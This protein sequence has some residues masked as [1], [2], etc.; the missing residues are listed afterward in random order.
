MPSECRP[1]CSR[2]ASGI[3]RTRSRSSARS[4]SCP[5]WPCCCTRRRCGWS[6]TDCRRGP[7]PPAAFAPPRRSPA[8]RLPRQPHGRTAAGQGRAGGRGAVRVQWPRRDRC[9]FGGIDRGGAGAAR[10]EGT[11]AGVVPRGASGRARKAEAISIGSTVMADLRSA[12]PLP[13]FGGCKKPLLRPSFQ[14]SPLDTSGNLAP[15]PGL[16]RSHRR[17]NW[18][19]HFLDACHRRDE[20]QGQGRAYKEGRWVHSILLLT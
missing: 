2:R 17:W 7:A 20:Q 16:S 8:H 19:T 12:P 3:P 15:G 9:V 14:P 5:R 11:N 13:M 1:A 4:T 10:D 6:G 18:N